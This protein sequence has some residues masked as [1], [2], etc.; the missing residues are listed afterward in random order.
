[1]CQLLRYSTAEGLSESIVGDGGGECRQS[2]K[3]SL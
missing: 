1:M 3:A 2:A